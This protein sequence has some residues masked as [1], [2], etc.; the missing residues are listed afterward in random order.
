MSEHRSDER[1]GSGRSPSQR[2]ARA[3]E[4]ARRR[5]STGP[6]L[7]PLAGQRWAS[8][9]DV[10]LRSTGF[11]AESVLALTDPELAAAADAAMRRCR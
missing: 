2:W 3:H 4:Q 6:H 10:V 7:V 9:R 5:A 1:A 8:W 11:P